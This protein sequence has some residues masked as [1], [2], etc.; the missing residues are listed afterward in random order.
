MLNIFRILSLANADAFIFRCSKKRA[1]HI[2]RGTTNGHLNSF[3]LG[4]FDCHE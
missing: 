3:S 2:S 4:N 1:K